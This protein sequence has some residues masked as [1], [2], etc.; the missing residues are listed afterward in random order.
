[1]RGVSQ[2][3]TIR[4]IGPLQVGIIVLVVATAF[5]HLSLALASGL[6]VGLLPMLW[7]LNCIGYLFLGACLYMPQLFHIQRI[8]R[9]VLIGYT[10]LTIVLWAVITHADPFLLA[11]I[12]KVIEVA[13]IVLLLVEDRQAQR[14]GM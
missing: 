10:A 12:D 9:W 4:R 3:Q 8:V 5:D 1:M 7:L 11:Y 6:P 14:T 13:L 2:G